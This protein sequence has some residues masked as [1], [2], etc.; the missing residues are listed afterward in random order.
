MRKISLVIIHCFF[1]ATVTY[2]QGVGIGTTTPNASA[3]LDVSATNKGVLVPRLAL[4]AANVASPV[5]SP[6][7]ALL[8]FNTSTSGS[9]TD[10][11][12]PGFYYW[13]A[14]SSRWTSLSSSA[15]PEGDVGFGA[16]GDCSVTAINEY[17]PAVSNDGMR[18]DIFG[19]SVCMSDNFAI[20][21]APY[22]SVGSNAKQGSAYIFSFNG[23]S[24]VQQQKLVANDGAGGDYFG[25]SVSISGNYA[26]VGAPLDAIGAVTGQGS[27]YIF[28]Y[29]GTTWVQ[30]QKIT[31]SDGLADDHFGF[32]VAITSSFALIG[33]KD[34]DIGANLSQGSSYVYNNNAGVWSQQPRLTAD[35]GTANEAFG[36]SVAL[37][38]NYA[39]IGA[40]GDGPLGSA[41]VFFYNGANWVQK[42]KLIP[43]NPAAQS[44]GIAVSISGSYI[45]IGAETTTVGTSNAQG[46]AFI[47]FYNGSTWEEQQ[48]L[49]AGDG[50]VN[51]RFG[52]KVSVSGNYALIGSI[53]ADVGSNVDQGATYLFQN[54]GGFWIRKQKITNPSG[55]AAEFSGNGSVS[56]NRFII[57]NSAFATNRGQVLFGKI[58]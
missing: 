34:D 23:S 24:W 26:I 45:C 8:I 48:E 19:V 54:A 36:T 25:Y 2:S 44:F 47:F 35:D 28:F 39:V 4:T 38:G 53:Q 14:T 40:Y 11:V 13:S 5:S 37:S 33:V 42:Q 9:G 29:N 43:T 52:G 55:A 51:D 30:Q 56:N 6:A 32:T 22:D 50:N 20:V 57:G 1:F 15:S 58:K 46:S 21:G 3:Q 12:S 10:A 18:G 27:A 7:D 17:Q 16:W 31:A 41:Y 49:I